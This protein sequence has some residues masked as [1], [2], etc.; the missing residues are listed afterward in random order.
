[1]RGSGALGT[2]RP[3]EPHTRHG[4]PVALAQAGSGQ[5]PTTQG[6]APS[7]RELVD[8]QGTVGLAKPLGDIRLHVIADRVP[9]C[10][11]E[12]AEPMECAVTCVLG[13]LPAVLPANGPRTTVIEDSRSR[14]PA[15]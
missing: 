11:A 10:T 9:L 14:I 6:P 3:E 1:M 8:D 4:D 15:T 5:A 7:T 12:R 2:A 13:E